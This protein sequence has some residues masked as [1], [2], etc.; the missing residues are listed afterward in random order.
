MEAEVKVW[1]FYCGPVRYQSAVNKEPVHVPM[2]KA[3]LHLPNESMHSSCGWKLETNDGST[4]FV[5]CLKIDAI[6]VKQV[7]ELALPNNSGGIL[8][9]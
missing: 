3:A 6:E 4:I 8:T 5:Y 1:G 9:S 2:E 7:S